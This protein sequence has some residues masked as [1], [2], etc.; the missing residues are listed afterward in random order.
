M[1]ILD[2]IKSIE[3]KINLIMITSDKCYE[4]VETFYGYKEIDQLGG[5][6]PIV[7]QKLVRDNLKLLRKEYYNKIDNIS[8]A[9]ARAGNVI[10]EE[11]G[12]KID[13]YPMPLMHGKS[14]QF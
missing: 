2:S 8:I 5:K 4:N 9:T 13:S 14:K 10:G 11:I 6:D 1:N 12:Q 7:H 3:K